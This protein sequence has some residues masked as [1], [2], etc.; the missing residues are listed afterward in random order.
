MQLEHRLW[1]GTPLAQWVKRWTTDLAVPTSILLSRRNH[2]NRKPGS[3]AHSLSLSTSNRPDMTEI[4]L[5]RSPIHPSFTAD[6]DSA[7]SGNG[8]RGCQISRPALHPLRYGAPKLAKIT[9]GNDH[10][11]SG[12]VRVLNEKMARTTCIREV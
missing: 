3:I 6:K 7:S 4:L 10:E 1:L 8:A 11:D 2:L 12:E 5:K 9:C